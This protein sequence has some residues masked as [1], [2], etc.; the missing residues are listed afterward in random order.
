MLA[1]DAQTSGGLLICVPK[2]KA[3]K[4]LDD[5]IDAGLT[6][7]KVIGFVSTHIEKHILMKN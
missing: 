2:A 1:F 7:S 4:I 6:D 5:L 3:R